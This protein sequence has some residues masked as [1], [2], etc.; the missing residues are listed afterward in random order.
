MCSKQ[1]RRFKSKRA[2]LDYR[3]KCRKKLTN[4]RSCECKCRFDE[5]KNVIQIT[6]GITISV[7]VSVE[8]AMYVKRIIFR[9]LLHVVVKMENI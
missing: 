7:K 1:N 9:I 2:Q 4:D 5:K 6:G 3:I 8:N